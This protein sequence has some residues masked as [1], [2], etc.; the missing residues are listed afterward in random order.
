MRAI[1][2]KH[3]NDV[4]FR[5]LVRQGTDLTAHSAQRSCMVLAP[6]PDDE[7]LGCGVMMLR[8]RSAGQAVH[9]VFIT[10]GRHS[11]PPT[12]AAPEWL[13]SQRR[14]EAHHACEALGV[15]PAHR[16]F[17]ELEDGTSR[18]HQAALQQKLGELFRH[19]Q[20]DYVFVPSRR[21]RHPDH[22]AVHDAPC[23]LSDEVGSRF[24]E[25]PVWFWEPR[26]WRDADASRV[27]GLGQIVAR[28]RAMLKAQQ[29]HL[30]PTRGWL[31]AKGLALDCYQTQLSSR[32]GKVGWATL[33]EPFVAQFFRPFEVFFTPLTGL[34]AS[35]EPKEA[36]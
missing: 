31:A 26:S 17:L 2:K 12:Q 27:R 23:A 8:R 16:H 1:V 3:Y 21:D 14:L 19:H 5:A 6:H 22:V 30:V 35:R 9:V 13:I 32:P 18:Y 33:P 34:V 29:A 25:Y 28:R 10:D 15:A 7:T 24:F 36:C 4:F 20:P 11:H